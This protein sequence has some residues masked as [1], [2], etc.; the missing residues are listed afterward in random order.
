MEYWTGTTIKK[1]E[2]KKWWDMNWITNQMKR[3]LERENPLLKHLT[4]HNEKWFSQKYILVCENNAQVCL[5]IININH[6][7]HIR[8]HL[9][10]R[11]NLQ[12]RVHFS[13]VFLLLLFSVHARWFFF[14]LDLAICCCFCHIDFFF[15]AWFILLALANANVTPIWWKYKTN[16]QKEIEWEIV[17]RRQLESQR[18]LTDA[19][20][21]KQW[22]QTK[23]RRQR[24]KGWSR[25]REIIARVDCCK[26][27]RA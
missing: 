3:Y 23:T 16:I 18:E 10:I 19:Q 14:F 21:E 5:K 26:S 20:S 7:H 8:S 15:I 12:Y 22:E 2:N 6:S 17:T 4:W 27:F 9:K 24:K 1:A 13:A 11:K 25:A